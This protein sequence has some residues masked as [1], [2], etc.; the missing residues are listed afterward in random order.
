[1]RIRDWSS[2]VCSSDLSPQFD[3]QD[4]ARISPSDVVQPELRYLWNGRDDR[5]TFVPFLRL[6]ADAEKRSHG[7]IRELNWYHAGDDWDTV[8]R[9]EERSVGQECVR[10]CRARGSPAH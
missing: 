2:D 4:N 6:D 5:V 8:L 3:E 7:D 10:T 1:M 9:S